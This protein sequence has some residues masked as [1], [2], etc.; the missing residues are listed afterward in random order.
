MTVV[1]EML[2]AT[3]PP[4]WLAIIVGGAMIG[5]SVYLS[6]TWRDG[7]RTVRD[8][9]IAALFFL[10]GGGLMVYGATLLFPA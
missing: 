5:N 10:F 7:E 9:L 3:P 4:P 8:A 1:W 2:G 6:T